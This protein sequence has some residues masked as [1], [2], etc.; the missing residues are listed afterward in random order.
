MLNS[1]FKPLLE[2]YLDINEKFQNLEAADFIDTNALD[3][4]LKNFQKDAYGDFIITNNNITPGV[5]DVLPLYVDLK[6]K[7]LKDYLYNS[8]KEILKELTDNNI[9]IFW[10]RKETYHISMSLMQDLRPCDMA[11]KKLLD[12]RLSADQIKEATKQIEI[13][14]E[15][16]PNLK[17]ELYGLSI[18]RGGSLTALFIDN[19][20]YLELQKKIDDKLNSFSYIPQRKYKKDMVHMTLAR[21]LEPVSEKLFFNIKKKIKNYYNL[22]DDKQYLEVNEI[23]FAHEIQWM[24]EKIESGSEVEL[25]LKS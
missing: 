3:I 21:I 19:G 13:I 1:Y 4:M 14:V 25:K 20:Q 8:A 12:T 23:I 17:L 16:N 10:T 9:K 22:L 7:K 24:H 11:D 2:K 18:G 5:C 15:N 6:D